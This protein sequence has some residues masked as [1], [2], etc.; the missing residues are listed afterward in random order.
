MDDR[1]LYPRGTMYLDESYVVGH[2]FATIPYSGFIENIT[3]KDIEKCCETM[4]PRNTTRL[5]DTVLEA[6]KSQKE[7]IQSQ[8]CTAVLSLF[9]DGEDNVSENT[10]KEMSK[11]IKEHRDRGVNCQFLAANQDSIKTGKTFGLS[12]GE[13]ITFS[14]TANG[15]SN[16]MKSVSNAVGRFYTQD[17]SNEPECEREHFTECERNASCEP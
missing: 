13:C 15:S 7:R 16:V 14:S 17:N 2:V 1:G 4:K 11:A 12:K 9:T 6:I 10:F 3:E 5:F 8:K